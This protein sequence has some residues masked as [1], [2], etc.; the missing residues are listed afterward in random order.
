MKNKAKK[1][2]HLAVALA[3]IKS[4]GQNQVVCVFPWCGYHGNMHAINR[5]ENKLC[6]NAKTMN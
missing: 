6:N 3:S 4:Y 2:L 5:L 1:T